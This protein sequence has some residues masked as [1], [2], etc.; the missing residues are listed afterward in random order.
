MVDGNSLYPGTM[1]TH[2]HTHSLIECMGA[3]QCRVYTHLR[4]DEKIDF[5]VSIKFRIE[6]FAI[7]P[8]DSS[9]RP[10]IANEKV[11]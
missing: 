9:Y 11:E 3:L 8:H 7:A 1:H 10:F 6:W 4:V 2:T 5:K